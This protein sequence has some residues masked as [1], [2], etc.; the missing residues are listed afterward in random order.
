M[1]VID[2]HL[3]RFCDFR[4][5]PMHLLKLM[6]FD[7]FLV[8]LRPQ[9]WTKGRR[10]SSAGQSAAKGNSVGTSL[11]EDLWSVKKPQQKAYKNHVE[12]QEPARQLNS[13]KMLADK[14]I[15][16]AFDSKTT[17]SSFLI[18]VQAESSGVPGLVKGFE[19]CRHFI[20]KQPVYLA[21]M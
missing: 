17:N 11:I 7:G 15:I 1:I 3:W 8:R 18:F 9:R 20:T 4:S 14:Q 5:E 13:P 19:A 16:T 10:K 6:W 12:L 21:E 2:S